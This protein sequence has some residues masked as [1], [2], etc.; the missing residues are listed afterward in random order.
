MKMRSPVVLLLSL[1]A[2]KDKSP[3]TIKDTDAPVE[4]ALWEVVATHERASLMSVSGQ[5]DASVWAVGA[6]DEDGGLILRWDGAAWTRIANSDTHDLWWVH[7]FDDGSVV[8]VGAGGTVLR[9]DEGGLERMDSPGLGAQTLYGAWGSAPDDLW[10]VGGFAGRWGFAWHYDG[11]GWEDVALPDDMPLSS[12][13]ELPSLFKVWGR[14]SDDVWIVGGE[15]TVLHWD[16]SA[17]SRIDSGSEAL[18]FTVHGDDDHVAIVGPQTVL[19]GGVDGLEEVSPDGAGL[20]QGACVEPDGTLMVTGQSGTIWLRDEAGEWE[21]QLNAT[22]V[23]PESLH[24]AWVDPSGGRWAVGGSVLSA[25]LDEG[26]IFHQG[27]LGDAWEAPPAPEPEPAACADEDIDPEPDASIARRWNEQIL[28][29]IRRDIPRPGVHAR[30]LFHVSA[31]MWDGWAVYDDV[32]DPY[33]STERIAIEDDDARAAAREVTM[34]TAAYRVAVHRYHDQVGGETS[35][36]CFDAFMEALG[37]DPDDTHTDGDDAVAVGNRIGEAIVARFADDGANEADNYADTTGWAPVN[38]PLVVDQ[39]GVD[40]VDPDDFQLLNLAAAETQ[41]G[42]VL[43][44]GLQSYIGA[45]WGLVTS[46]AL[47]EERAGTWMVLDPGGDF[48]TVADPASKDWVLDVIRKHA[49]LDP[50]LPETVDISPGAYGNNTLGENDGSGHALNP[51]TGSPYTENVVPLGDFTRVLAEFWADG[52]KSETPPG[53]WNTLANT[54]SDDLDPEALAIAELGEPLDRLAWDTHLYFALN[55]ALHDAAIAAWGAK[56]ESLGSR[57]ISW[58]RWMAENGQSSDDSLPSYHPD[59]L[60]LEDGVVELIT[61]DSAAPGERHHHLRWFV[62]EIAV[63]SWRGEPGDRDAVASGVAWMRAKEWFPYQRRTFVT[64][65][66]P[67]YVSGHSTFSRA[68]AEV[69]TRLTGSPWFPGGLGEYVAAQDDYL[70]FEQGPSVEVRL[71]WGTYQ[72]AADQA[73]QSRLWGGIH[74][75]PDDTYGRQLGYDVGHLAV[76]EALTWFEGSAR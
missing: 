4:D 46:F 17:L 7:A 26:V 28:N 38:D 1:A 59:G 70:V 58:I 2:C 14:S 42:I 35:E 74:L 5:S 65:A 67:G 73:G 30:N 50:T 33:E 25:A 45:Q 11:T 9:G 63:L 6:A 72:D 36:A 27:A 24:A 10:V 41:N 47:G 49:R 76:D 8:A 39:P 75:W 61:D 32:A 3:A 43:D 34:A 31:A 12:E 62:G 40:M 56:R 15:G 52:P 44:T 71:Q 48:P 55:G 51:V 53:H 29:A 37:L 68:G 66:F 19:V 13:G 57:P 54:V 20:L 60:P 22:G 16:G 64:P 69:L 23:S 21:Q 18:L